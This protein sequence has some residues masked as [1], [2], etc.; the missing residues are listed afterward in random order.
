VTPEE[1]LL[2]AA[3]D[4]ATYGHAKE[5]FYAGTLK[6][7]WETAPACAYG[8]LARVAGAANENGT[9][10]DVSVGTLGEAAKKLAAQIR[11]SF[12]HFSHDDPYFTITRYNDHDNTTGEDV[13]LAMKEAAH[14]G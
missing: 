11:E 1:I 2:K 9:V 3:E 14:R 13:I 6:G 7:N 10:T 4:L 5:K 8:S 12:P